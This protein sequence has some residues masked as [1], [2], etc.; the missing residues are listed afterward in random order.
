MGRSRLEAAAGVG[1]ERYRQHVSFSVATHYSVGS[2]S[3][4][5]QEPLS[6]TYEAE[7]TS[8]FRQTTVEV[9]ASEHASFYVQ[10]AWHRYPSVHVA[11]F[12]VFYYN[13]PRIQA[14]RV[15]DHAVDFGYRETLFGTRIHF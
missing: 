2:I 8:F 6:Y 9:Y 13:D 1:V 7:G 11:E 14:Y 10:W 3:A 5:L 4:L 15:D 12:G